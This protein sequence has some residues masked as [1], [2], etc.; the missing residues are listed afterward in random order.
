MTSDQGLKHRT[1]Q[2]GGDAQDQPSVDQPQDPGTTERRQ[3]RTAVAKRGLRSL[4]LAVALPVTLTLL[5]VYLFGSNL[6][7][8]TMKKSFLYP[9]LWALHLACVASAFLMG[10]SGWLVWA[11]GGFHRSPW[12]LGLYL[13]QLGSGLAWY[14]IVFQAGASR[15]GLVLCAALFGA[16]VGC[17]RMFRRVNPIA[18]DLVK[19]TLFWALLLA[20][21]NVRLVY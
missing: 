19:F 20:L 15:V 9:P 16:L 17:I 7:Y 3:K 10:L 1:I 2:E 12:S 8:A 14:P 5:D 6:H 21:V 13:G 11:D 18:G 4:G